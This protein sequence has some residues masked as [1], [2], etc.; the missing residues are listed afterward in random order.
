MGDCAGNFM[1]FMNAPRSD[2]LRF[3][4]AMIVHGISAGDPAFRDVFRAE[5]ELDR[6]AHVAKYK[7]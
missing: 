2:W 5:Y 4:S 7:A 1:N 3:C 6:R